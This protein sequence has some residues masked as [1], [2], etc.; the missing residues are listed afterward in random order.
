M[1]AHAGLVVRP[2][3]RAS[4]PPAAAAA[5]GP[6]GRCEAAGLAR[7]SRGPPSRTGEQRSRHDTGRV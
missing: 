4:R 3:G 2:S 1:L 7:R 5:W 6:P